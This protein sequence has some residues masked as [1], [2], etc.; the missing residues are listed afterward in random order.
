M[1][2][3]F[4]GRVNTVAGEIGSP[5]GVMSRA[6][7]AESGSG[8]ADDVDDGSGG[9]AGIGA[10][11]AGETGTEVTATAGGAAAGDVGGGGLKAIRQYS[12][13]ITET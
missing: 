6:M 11:E 4:I 13:V 1:A 5:F 7:T 10:G 8:A 3:A 2:T 9:A 12:Y